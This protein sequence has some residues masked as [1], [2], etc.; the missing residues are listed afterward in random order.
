MLSGDLL[1]EYFCKLEKE[2]CE[3]TNINITHNKYYINIILNNY[4]YM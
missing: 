1:I 3:K 4:L 2:S